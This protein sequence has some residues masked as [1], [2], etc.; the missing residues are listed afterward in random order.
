M[1]SLDSIYGRGNHVCAQCPDGA[2]PSKRLDPATE[3]QASA[4]NGLDAGDLI[5]PTCAAALTADADAIDEIVLDR[6][7]AEDD[8]AE[9][10]ARELAAR[11]YHGTAAILRESTGDARVGALAEIRHALPGIVRAAGVAA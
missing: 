3:R 6:E 8:G 5:C 7:A 11:G 9:D 4:A 2:R 10:I 1:L